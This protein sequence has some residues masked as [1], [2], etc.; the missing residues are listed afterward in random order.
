MAHQWIQGPPVAADETDRRLFFKVRNVLWDY[1]PLRASG[2]QLAID[3][4]HQI[5][6]VN[7]RVRSVAQKQL[8]DALVRRVDGVRGVENGIVADPEIAR[9]VALAL[10]RDP[11]LAAHVIQ[12][13]SQLGE[14]TLIGAVPNDRLE[15]RAVEIAAGL[16]I[17]H[18]VQSGLAIQPTPVGAGA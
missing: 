2:A 5:V 16:G 18:S 8:V 17:V 3:V 14:V 12:V 1:E 13:V 4:Q 15:Q 9:D 6:Q 11:E 7:G 10:A